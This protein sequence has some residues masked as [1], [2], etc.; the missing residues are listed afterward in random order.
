VSLLEKREAVLR[1]LKSAPEDASYFALGYALACLTG[2]QL[3]ELLK[4]LEGRAE[5]R[6][7]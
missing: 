5:P 1:F 2:G 4:A 6:K 7:Q 3:S